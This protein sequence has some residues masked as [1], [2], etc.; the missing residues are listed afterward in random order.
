VVLNIVNNTIQFSSNGT[1][2][3]NI[4]QLTTSL[5]KEAVGKVEKKAFQH[6]GMVLLCNR[7]QIIWQS[8]KAEE[9]S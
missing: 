5:N 6:S 9:E 7:R 4:I 2:N 1:I 8:K 3:V